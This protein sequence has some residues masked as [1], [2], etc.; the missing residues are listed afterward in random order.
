MLQDPRFNDYKLVWAFIEPDKFDIC[1]GEKIKID[2]LQYYKILLAA[3]CWITNSTVERG[4]SF[5]GKNV[6]YF[7]TWHGTAIKKMGS[8]I[9]TQ[10]TSFA[11]KSENRVD[12]MLAQGQYDVDVF[13]RVFNIPEGN[14]RI[15]GL[16]RN[17]ELIAKNNE[18]NSKAIKEKLGI[19]QDKKVLL[20][21]PTFREYTK[22]SH[23]NCVTAPPITISKWEEALANDYVLLF[24]VHY[25]VVRIL[26]LPQS[27][28]VKDV[29]SYSNLNELMLVSDVLISDYSSIFFDYSIMAKPMLCFAYDY[30]E[31]A[32][33]RGMYFDI[34][35]SLCSME[36][37]DEELLL[38]EIIN[39]DVERR[40]AIATAFRDQ[41][42][43]AFGTA[44]QQSLDVISSAIM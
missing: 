38:S 15:T 23:G 11:S 32:K 5:K 42:I 24:R 36:L 28:F 9:D 13:S 20:Y 12:V 41:Y 17:D 18:T 14:F 22:D 16:P 3:R 35:E 2:T 26:N 27:D 31:Y 40:C 8:D 1:R 25:E 19:P 44:S 30:D 37:N 4:L 43:T 34:R 10:N 6:F 33:N 39:M 29:S 21:A 7:N